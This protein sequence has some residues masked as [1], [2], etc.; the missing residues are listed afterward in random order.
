MTPEERRKLFE[1]IASEARSAAEPVD[2]DALERDGVLSKEGVWYR[3]H[4]YESLPENAAA[5]ISEIAQDAKGIKV[6]FYKSSSF[7]KIA[8]KFEKLGY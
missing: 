3:I 2:F 5:R 7:E 4:R 6:K 1:Q 8:K